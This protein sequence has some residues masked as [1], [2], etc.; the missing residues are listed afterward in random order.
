MAIKD[1]VKEK[2]S[3]LSDRYGSWKQERKENNLRKKELKEKE[4][5]AELS[6]KER[7]EL[8]KLSPIKTGT[9]KAFSNA[10]GLLAGIFKRNKDNSSPSSFHSTESSIKWRIN[11]FI[12][13]SL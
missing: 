10:T 8:E 4:K 3:D 1:W 2:T 6:E 9:K 5:E 13:F 7:E 12:L 11:L